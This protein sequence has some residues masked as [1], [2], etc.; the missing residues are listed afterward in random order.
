MPVQI[1]PKK[2]KINARVSVYGKKTLSAKMKEKMNKLS[3]D[4]D[5]VRAIVFTAVFCGVCALVYAGKL[6]SAYI[7]Y[8]LAVVIPSPVLLDKK[9]DK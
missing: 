4:V 2:T 8:L 7:K 3:L 5:V 6:D 9:D 1:L